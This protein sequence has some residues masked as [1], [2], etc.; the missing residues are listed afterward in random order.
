MRVYLAYN[1][2]AALRSGRLS[3]ESFSFS[4]RWKRSPCLLFPRVISGGRRSARRSVRI[5]LQSLLKLDGDDDCEYILVARTSP[6]LTDKPLL[7]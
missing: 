3:V 6:Y 7:I 2:S 4:V 5:C 1:I